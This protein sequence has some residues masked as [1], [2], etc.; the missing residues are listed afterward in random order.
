LQGFCVKR[1]KIKK[2]LFTMQ[3][4]KFSRLFFAVIV[5][6]GIFT[7]CKKS[8]ADLQATPPAT[9]TVTPTATTADPEAIKDSTL[10]FTKDVY[11]WNTQIPASFN[12]RGY[13]D[14]DAIMQAIHPYSIESGFAQ[15]VDRWSFAMK[16]DEWDKQSAGMSALFSDE[17]PQSGDFGLSVFF[18][19]EGDLRVRLVEPNSPAGLAGIKRSWRITSIN[20]SANVTTANASTIVDA[21]Y[22]A[23]QTSFKFVKPDGSEVSMTLNAGHYSNKPVYLD[24][25]YSLGAQRVGYLVYNSFLGNTAQ[26]S[27]EFQRVFS[28]FA[29]QQV[30]DVVIDLRYNG[31]G[32]V[33]LAE[34]LANYLAPS[35]AQGG[36]MMKQVYNAGNTQ[37]NTTTYFNKRGSL[38]L[39]DIYFIVSKSTAS[40]S[41]L[42]INTLKPYMDVKLIGPTATH[43]KPV[44]FFPIPVGDWY[45]FPVS[46]RTTNKNGEGNYFNGLAVNAQVA[47]G[48]DKE[49]GDVTESC[50]ASALR[51]ISGG[52]FAS[53]ESYIPLSAQ[54]SSANSKLDAPFLKVTIGKK[55]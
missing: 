42:L 40:A 36:L 37:N 22:N 44:G 12:A 41:E 45:I 55:P 7:G 50:L 20:G 48:L 2:H 35:A 11:L 27:S 32:Y 39:P 30:T 43:G 24:S 4:I 13:A 9:T 18:R 38:N 54:T 29:S 46:F 31:G 5:S 51:N 1:A 14:P 10:T 15:P 17:T 25:V 53:E 3:A 23:T 33:S 19:A 52:G 28:R 8:T 16:K 47:D 34:Q 49:W 6:V 21:V 26:V